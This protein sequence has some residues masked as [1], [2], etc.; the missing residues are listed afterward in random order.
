MLILSCTQFFVTTHHADDQKYSMQLSKTDFIHFLNCSK[1]LWLLKHKP[2]A[3]SYGEF[4]DFMKKIAAEGY[5][6]EEQVRAYLNAQPDAS[7][8]SWQTVFETPRGLYA[9]ADVIRENSDGTINIYEVKSSTSVKKDPKHNQIKDAAFQKI[10]AEETGAKVARVFVVH[11]NKEYVRAGE[12]DPGNLLVFSDV[13]EAVGQVEGETREEAVNAL[14]ALSLTKIDES[15]C[16]CLVRTRSNH[17]DSFEHFN[18]D[19]P[20]PSI[21][22]LP[23]ISKSKLSKFVSEGRLHLDDIGLDD[24]TDK[25]ALVVKSAHLREPVIDQSELSRFYSKAKYPIYF[26]DYETYSAAIPLVDGA[27]PHA[28]I[29]FQYSL[30][31]KRTPDDMELVHSEYLADNPEMPLGM[32]EH[33]QSHIGAKGSVVSWHA[34]F[35]NAQNR[36]MAKL[37]PHKAE[38]LN[39]LIDRTLDLEDLFKSGYVD[40]A[41]GGSTSIK[42]VLPVLAPD[43]TYEGMDIANGTD[44]MEAWSKLI[45]MKDGAERRELREAMLEYC[46]LDTYAMV[47]IFEEVEQL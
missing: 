32:I 39:D 29:P 15:S 8:Y 33:M 40:I 16:S 9:K 6:V 21:Y 13:T 23:R 45:E 43:L 12:I 42:K 20:T 3:Y 22:D 37:Y 1:S 10:V 26:L 44:A 7:S 17:C 5:E 47:R 38:F 41:F 35:E 4:S 14:E 19:L 18:P 11:L 34:S 2:D 24:V 46:K 28:P 25:Q 36:S 27:S 30:H 31:V